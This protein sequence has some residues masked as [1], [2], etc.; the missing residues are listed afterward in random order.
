M[1]SHLFISISQSKLVICCP[2]IFHPLGRSHRNAAKCGSIFLH[3]FY[4]FLYEYFLYLTLLINGYFC[5]RKFQSP[6]VG[7]TEMHPYG[8]HLSL[9]FLY[10]PQQRFLLSNS[11][12]QSAFLF[13]R[14]FIPGVGANVIPTFEAPFEF[15]SFL[16][17]QTSFW[18]RILKSTRLLLPANIFIPPWGS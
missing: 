8:A 14:F 7:A 10:L 12:L 11:R 5:P 4:M 6:L 9:F 15:L 1:S 18:S 16:C 3:L 17:Q 13:P 2:S